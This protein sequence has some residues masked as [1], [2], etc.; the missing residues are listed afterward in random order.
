MP[1][2]IR[3]NGIKLRLCGFEANYEI[4]QFFLSYRNHYLAPI[5][6]VFAFVVSLETKS[7]KY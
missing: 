5:F 4:L 1:Q 3:E 6:I 2:N 7:K